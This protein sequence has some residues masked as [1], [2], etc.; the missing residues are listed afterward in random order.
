[1]SDRQDYLTAVDQLVQGEIPLSEAD[2]ILA[3]D[4]AVREH[5]KHRP[6]EIVE[7]FDGDGGFDYA[8]SDF[9]DWEDG[10][11]TIRQV[12]YPVDDDDETPDIL[13]AADWMIYKKPAGK[14]LRFLSATPGTEEDFRVT[15]TALHACTDED[16]TVETFDELAVQALAAAYFCDMLA[17]YYAQSQD[18]TIGADSVDHASKSRDYAARAK[19]YRKV[20]Q[21]HMGI[22]DGKPKPACGVQDQDQNYPWGWDRLTHPRRNR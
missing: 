3:V 20:Y 2:K 18:S 10:F 8:L 19:R 4:L 9:S 21:D 7:D 22:T 14:Y 13:E 17:V 15:Y 6:Q 12:E 11:S 16:C 5:S 1:M